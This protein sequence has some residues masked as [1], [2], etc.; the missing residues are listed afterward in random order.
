MPIAATVNA[1]ARSFVSVEVSDSKQTF[2]DELAASADVAMKLVLTDSPA[3]STGK[4]GTRMIKIIDQEADAVITTL[5]TGRARVYT[6]T[7]ELYPEDQISTIPTAANT[8]ASDLNTL[9]ALAGLV[10]W[11]KTGTPV[12]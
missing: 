12:V 10:S 6:F 3:N 8:A 11:L 1:I 4:K 2:I 5:G 7:Y 9:G